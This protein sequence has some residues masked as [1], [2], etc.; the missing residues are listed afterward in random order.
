MRADEKSATARSALGCP[1][2]RS[3][4]NILPRISVAAFLREGQRKNAVDGDATL[5]DEVGEA[6]GEDAGFPRAGAR[7]DDGVSV[8][9]RRATLRGTQL[10]HYTLVT[11][12]GLTAYA[13]RQMRLSRIESTRT[14]QGREAS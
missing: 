3:I 1:A 14:S 9:A 13:R 4:L 8:R 5:D 10:G 6:S 12:R 11:H 2:S 7:G